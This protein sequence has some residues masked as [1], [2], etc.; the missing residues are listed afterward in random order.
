MY[1]PKYRPEKSGGSK[2][3]NP[4]YKPGSETKRY[5]VYCFYLAQGMGKANEKNMLEI[6][7]AW[8]TSQGDNL[9]VAVW[10]QSGE[11]Y[12]HFLAGHKNIT[13]IPAIIL[14]NSEN[15]DGDS[16][17]ITLQEPHLI[18]NTDKVTD[19]LA[20]LYSYMLQEDFVKSAK[21]AARENQWAMV[22]KYFD[23]VK[24]I[25]GT[26]KISLAHG[27]LTVESK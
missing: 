25:F 18:S 14:S 23:P 27:A 8:G 5:P 13:N 21:M 7:K 15:F 20:L 3:I 2:A 6:L 22:Q 24:G 1:E 12:R 4:I 26:L 11:E 17:V 16:F 9:L 19:V 10:D